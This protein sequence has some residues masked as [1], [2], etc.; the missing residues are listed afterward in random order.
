[1]EKKHFSVLGRYQKPIETGSVEMEERGRGYGE[2]ECEGMTNKIEKV[3][4]KGKN[5]M[6][7]K[8]CWTLY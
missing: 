3:G 6:S 2:E 7:I 5:L 8:S 4:R 1:M